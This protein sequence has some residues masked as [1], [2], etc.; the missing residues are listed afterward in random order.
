VA[1]D[2]LDNA[3]AFAVLPCSHS[4]YVSQPGVVANLIEKAASEVRSPAMA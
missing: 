3:G 4:I 1:A 2:V